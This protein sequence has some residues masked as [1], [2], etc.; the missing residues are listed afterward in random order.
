MLEPLP[1]RQVRLSGDWQV[2]GR[3]TAARGL[4][5][6]AVR[7]RALPGWQAG[8]SEAF[9]STG[10]PGEEGAGNPNGGAAGRSG[11][12]LL[13]AS[14]VTPAGSGLPRK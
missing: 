2:R 4:S 5:Q 7:S 12:H 6:A 3:R 1:G 10:A 11:V 8:W 13:A 14:T 9:R